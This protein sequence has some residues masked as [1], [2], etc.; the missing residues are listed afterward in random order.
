MRARGAALKLQAVFLWGPSPRTVFPAGLSW[1]ALSGYAYLGTSR[2]W[3]HHK[4]VRSQA[5]KPLE[6]V[7][8]EAQSLCIQR[9]D[10]L[11]SLPHT[12]RLHLHISLS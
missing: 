10:L 7:R 2:V 11:V 9:A 1:K 5:L 6:E 8:K 3:E 4:Y 12:S